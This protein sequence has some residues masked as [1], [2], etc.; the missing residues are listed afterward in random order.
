[1]LRHIYIIYSI[2][3]IY[4]LK[5]IGFLRNLYFRD[6]SPGHL[7]VIPNGKP[8]VFFSEAP[9]ARPSASAAGG[10]WWEVDSHVLWRGAPERADI[11]MQ[12][13]GKNGGVWNIGGIY[14]YIY[15]QGSIN[16]GTPMA[17][18]FNKGKSYENDLRPWDL[19]CYEM[20]SYMIMG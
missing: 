11:M 17:G 8:S 20:N 5:S 16:G 14:I 2:P 7:H 9:L 12:G 10:W 3:C 18:W 15:L 6:I 1:M 19:W 13:S 4:Q